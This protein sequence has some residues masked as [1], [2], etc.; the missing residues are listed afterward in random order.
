ML[1]VSYAQTDEGWAEWIA[2]QLR[3]DGWTVYLQEWRFV[4]GT[5]FATWMQESLAGA[6]HVLTVLSDAYLRSA[7]GQAE[8]QARHQPS[9][10]RIIPVRVERCEPVGLLG[11]SVRIDL[12]DLEE[13]EA[14][15]VL[16]RGVRAAAT[17][18]PQP[19]EEAPYR[20]TGHSDAGGKPSQFPIRKV[21][22][23]FF[24]RVAHACRERYPGATI[25][26]NPRATPVPYLDLDGERDGERQRWPV[27]VAADGLD[28][29]AL[30][31]FHA[32]VHLTYEPPGDTVESEL[33]YSGPLVELGLVW[34]GRHLGIQVR[35]LAE[36]EGRWD[37]RRYLARQ[38]ERI[39]NDR[40]YPP[41]LYVPQRFVLLDEPSGT[42]ERDDV[43][44]ATVDWLD[45]DAAFFLL[46]LA[47][48]G[49]GKT[50][51][52]RELARR[53]PEKLPNTVPMLVEIHTLEKT[54][55]IDDLLALHL[56]KTGEYGVDVR[57][58]R[59]MVERGRAILLFDGFDELASRV[60]YDRAS[61][62][63]ATFLSAVSGKAKVVLTGRTQHFASDSQWR[64]A[65]G[66]Q[67]GL[68]AA[69]R[70]IRLVD[71]DEGQIREF[72]VRR[73]T[74]AT[75]TAPSAVADRGDAETR[76]RAEQQAYGRL[77]R[78]RKIRD[79]I[80]LA[81][82]PR[83]LSFLADLGDSDLNA[84]S[85][86]GPGPDRSLAA[87]YERIIGQW[88]DH[89]V[90]RRRPTRG[91]QLGLTRNHIRRA[92]DGLA[93][94]LWLNQTD[95]I[96][97]NG[98]TGTVR[99]TL[100]DLDS[101]R[102]GV[103]EAAFAVGSGSLLVRV[104][105]DMFAFE[106]QSVADY[107]VA[108]VAVSEI[109]TGVAA[110]AVLAEREISDLVARFLIGASNP[111][112]LRDWVRTVL[113]VADAGPAVRANAL[114]LA[115][116][117]GVTAQ[118][119]Q[120]AGQDLRGQRLSGRDM[121]LANLR[122]AQL[123]GMQLNDTN[124]DGA[125]LA[126]ADLRGAH[127]ARV[128]L[129]RAKL[130]DADL[131]GAV[132]SGTDL[133]DALLA[134][135]RWHGAAIVGGLLGD[136]ARIPELAVAA[137]TTRDRA[138]PVF[139]PPPARAGALAYSPDGGLLAVAYGAGVL[140][141]DAYRHRPVGILTSHTGMVVDLAFTPNGQMVATAC[142][143]HTVRLQDVASGTDQA[144]FTSHDDQVNA[145][146]VSPDGTLLASA[147]TDGIRLHRI[148]TT[149]AE[150]GEGDL[151]IGEVGAELPWVSTMAFHPNS[152]LL[153]CGTTNGR[154]I[155]LSTADGT[156]VANQYTHHGWVYAVVFDATGRRLATT[157]EDGAIRLWDAKT[158]EGA[159]ILAGH[160]RA[161]RAAAFNPDGRYLASGSE[162][163][164]IRL[165]DLATGAPLAEFIARHSAAALA[166]HPDGHL[167]AAA[168]G[169]SINIREVKSVP[170]H[171]YRTVAEISGTARPLV[172]VAFSPDGAALTSVG[173]DRTTRTWETATGRHLAQGR[174]TDRGDNSDSLGKGDRIPSG[175][176]S[177]TCPEG[178][179]E[180]VADGSAV[181]LNEARTGTLIGRLTGHLGPVTALAVAPD[182]RLL[183]TASTDG[184]IRLWYPATATAVATLL[185]L[186]GGAW[187]VLLPDGTYKLDGN[188]RDE[189]WWAM[190]RCRFEP[191]ELDGF[192]DSLNRL[193][194]TEP[195][196][197]PGPGSRPATPM[198]SQPPQRQRWGWSRR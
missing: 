39:D 80:G 97:I 148:P 99:E 38:R 173:A 79:L 28:Q 75:T 118:G 54:P 24:D 22:G 92:V 111:D 136:S 34:R 67:V 171:D 131:R 14:R 141:L 185:G 42:P 32:R 165:W 166:F 11:H 76:S 68:L 128:S 147:S 169:E 129:R 104:E 189:L 58:V 139:P 153:A 137:I 101:L 83:M 178:Q 168:E 81:G 115:A 132:L 96:D 85:E 105:G 63:L 36:F 160:S 123:V 180:A 110:P 100:T 62:H 65:L 66:E 77:D 112:Q 179:L 125:D 188:P 91:S 194:P 108:T 143:D 78:L 162:D 196:S 151:H 35:S 69:S 25:R 57:V 119:I 121:H 86:V 174:H 103:D 89:E 8:W 44:A 52:L 74:L 47:D 164:S 187:A 2:W 87:L 134:G 142:S 40:N 120:L 23:T 94:K 31:A 88:L 12:F 90:A 20:A 21:S 113:A 43:F 18:Y 41:E 4:P 157:G 156:V 176:M 177:V 159:G 13:D 193:D 49:H 124:L 26:P 186:P 15:R 184:T 61:E 70:Q 198:A 197:G 17:G 82:N 126:G 175:P 127:L 33:V 102:T 154:L 152:G 53:L 37:P 122:G 109:G 146:A 51:L 45:I 16:L 98:L 138:A 71:F 84:I 133:R 116:S 150:L 46:I 140:L 117:L 95:T 59:R 182:G 19:D 55:S 135:S 6:D 3:Q 158:G 93:V 48:S 72:L 106:H 56:S 107:L 114:H 191:G 5:V 60:T 181:R 50:F 195:L 7:W 130:A 30:E 73:H 1:F 64:T 29:A 161:V 145:V 170:T 192:I 27:G 10:R 172:A 9:E 144:T 163:G 155:L 190:G 183:A 149:S 167:F